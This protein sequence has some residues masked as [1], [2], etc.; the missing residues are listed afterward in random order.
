M[1]KL[2]MPAPQSTPTEELPLLNPAARI[3]VVPIFDGHQCVIVDDFM[4]EPE[5]L[6]HYASA[7]VPASGNSGPG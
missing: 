2:S 1:S 6:V 5:A 4:L 7:N 3:S